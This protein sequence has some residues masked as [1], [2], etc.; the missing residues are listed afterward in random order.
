M[1]TCYET[2][3]IDFVAMR[4]IDYEYDNNALNDLFQ[5]IEKNTHLTPFEMLYSYLNSRFIDVGQNL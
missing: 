2:I 3:H 1:T 4:S 5:S